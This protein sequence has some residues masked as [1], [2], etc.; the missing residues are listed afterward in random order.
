MTAGTADGGLGERKPIRADRNRMEATTQIQPAS[1]SKD[2]ETDVAGVGQTI[3]DFRI[4]GAPKQLGGA[5]S[6]VTAT[7]RAVARPRRP[8]IA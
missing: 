5:A 2:Q 7:A 4:G 8:T 3:G 6:R 1:H